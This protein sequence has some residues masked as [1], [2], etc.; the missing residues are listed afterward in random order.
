MTIKE[1]RE[2]LDGY[3]EDTAVGI[4][5]PRGQAVW[6]VK[7]TYD[8]GYEHVELSADLEGKAVRVMWDE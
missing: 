1:L 3:A 4:R 8:A 6:P 7:A 2:M 5:G